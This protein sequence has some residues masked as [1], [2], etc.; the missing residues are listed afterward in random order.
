V[1]NEI[2]VEYQDF[3]SLRYILCVKQNKNN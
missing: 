1:I 3:Y 2:N